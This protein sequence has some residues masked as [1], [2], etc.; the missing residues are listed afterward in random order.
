MGENFRFGH[1]AQGDTELLRADGR[2]ETHVAPLV[3]ID[4]EVV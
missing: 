2:F 1:K 4:G 3:E